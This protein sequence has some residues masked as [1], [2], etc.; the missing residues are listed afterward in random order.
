MPFV[1]FTGGEVQADTF[2]MLHMYVFDPADPDK[3]VDLE[4]GQPTDTWTSCRLDSV[5][6]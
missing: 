3:G 6:N 2:G 5:M 4:L 1:S